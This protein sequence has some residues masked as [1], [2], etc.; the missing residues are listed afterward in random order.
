[1][2]R[3]LIALA[4]VLLTATPALAHTQ[5]EQE[6]WLEAWIQKAMVERDPTLEDMEELAD[7]KARHPN[8]I[9]ALTTS[10]SS[11]TTT[12]TPSGATAGVFTGMGA[13]VEQWRGLVA[14][15]FP[16]DQVDAGLRI[17]QCES[18]GN[19]NAWNPSGASG[20]MQVLASWADNFGYT[21]ADLFIPEVNMAI[22]RILYD[23]SVTRGLPLW[24]HW[25]CR[26]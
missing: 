10:Q 20:L 22:S 6:A 24:S 16:A 8:L 4:L 21:P 13:G 7:F 17:M 15:Y 25:E 12:K 2:R 14:A 11:P 23:D 3:C 9:P 26:P 18:G 5:A 19:P 1:M